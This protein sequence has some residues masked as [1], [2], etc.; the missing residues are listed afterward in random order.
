MPLIMVMLSFTLQS[1][2]FNL[3]LNMLQIQ[4]PLLLNQ[5]MIMKFIISYNYSTQN[6]MKIFWMLTSIG[7]KLDWCLPRPSIFY[8]VSTV[9]FHKY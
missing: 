5:F 4:K 9:F 8:T 2:Q 7:F 3:T 6:M 1:F